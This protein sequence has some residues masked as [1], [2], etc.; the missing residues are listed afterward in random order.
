MM[1]ICEGNCEQVFHVSLKK[2]VS[3]MSDAVILHS[4]IESLVVNLI[5][6]VVCC[7]LP[8]FGQSNLSMF[9]VRWPAIVA[10]ERM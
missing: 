3:L 5:P 7:R 9:S 6:L 8:L 2:F 1:V 4:F 10:V